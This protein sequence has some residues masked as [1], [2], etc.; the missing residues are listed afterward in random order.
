LGTS[1][2][3]QNFIVGNFGRC[4]IF[5]TKNFTFGLLDSKL[6]LEEWV[7]DSWEAFVDPLVWHL[8]K[9]EI[10]DA[11]IMTIKSFARFSKPHIPKNKPKPVSDHCFS[12]FLNFARKWPKFFP[13][14]Y[15]SLNSHMWPKSLNFLGIR[16]S[17]KI[18][19]KF[20]GILHSCRVKI[21][22]YFSEKHS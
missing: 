18:L 6:D 9:V 21:A 8:H 3:T 13:V 19:I 12:F 10:F 5:Q 1:F 2:V 20:H 17:F 4:N 14:I 7:R 11:L 22:L 15:K 16:L